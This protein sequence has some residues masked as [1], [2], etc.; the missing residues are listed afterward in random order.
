M[1]AMS[2]GVVTAWLFPAG[3]RRPDFA[4]TSIMRDAESSRTGFANTFSSTGGPTIVADMT[5][6][7]ACR[8]ANEIVE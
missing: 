3:L 4:V 1:D 6:L 2:C 8:G 7:Q 5:A